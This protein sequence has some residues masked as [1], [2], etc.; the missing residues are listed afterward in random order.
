MGLNL[1]GD[2]TCRY[3]CNV[4]VSVEHGSCGGLVQGEQEGLPYVRILTS[5]IQGHCFWGVGETLLQDFPLLLYWPLLIRIW[6]YI[7]NEQLSAVKHNYVEIW[8]I[9]SLYLELKEKRV[10]LMESDRSRYLK[11]I[12]ILKRFPGIQ[13]NPC[14]HACVIKSKWSTCAAA[15]TR[16][17][18][19]KTV[20]QR[21]VEHET[22]AWIVSSLLDHACFLPKRAEKR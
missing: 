9:C 18:G 7:S 21:D 4:I 16:M 14:N 6:N 2:H 20:K 8:G 3:I 12:L 15:E 5:T 17:P 13:R 10:Q 19:R 11:W 1:R 22:Q